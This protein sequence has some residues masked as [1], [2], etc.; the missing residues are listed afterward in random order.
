MKGKKV[1]SASPV[2]GELISRITTA[3][4]NKADAQELLDEGQVAI[5]TRDYMVELQ[6]ASHDRGRLNDGVETQ[7]EMGQ[8]L[9]QQAI[10]KINAIDAEISAIEKE[11]LAMG[12]DSLEIKTRLP[13][14]PNQT[15]YN[16][17]YQQKRREALSLFNNK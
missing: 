12:I 2:P 3:L 8:T 17:G 7:N 9:R 11:L 10:Q 6:A 15:N 5:Q 4:N 13:L 14:G 1:S 16:I